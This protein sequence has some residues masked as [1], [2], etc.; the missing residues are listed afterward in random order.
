[1]A[2]LIKKLKKKQLL[3]CNKKG[4]KKMVAAGWGCAPPPT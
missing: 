1:V 2:K 3:F 4:K